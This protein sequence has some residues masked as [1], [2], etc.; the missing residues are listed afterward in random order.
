MNR[1]Q[2]SAQ[3]R[4]VRSRL[5]QL[6]HSKPLIHATVNVRRLTCGKSGCRCARGEKHRA[7]YLVCNVQGKKRQVYVP[8]A[9]EEEVCQ[10]VENHRTALALLEE[11][12]D[13]AWRELDR[14][15]ENKDI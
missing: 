5:T 9:L 14:R 11:V 8:A 1:N 13:E 15:K 12:S 3:Q 4:A 6:I 2:M 10:W 7:L